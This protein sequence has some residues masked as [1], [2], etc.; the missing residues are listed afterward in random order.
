[1]QGLYTASTERSGKKMVPKM[2]S[3][4]DIIQAYKRGEVDVEDVVSLD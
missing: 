1:M 3:A 2:K 4:M